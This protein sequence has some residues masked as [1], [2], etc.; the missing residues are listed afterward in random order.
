MSLENY[1]CRR[2]TAEPETYQVS[3]ARSGHTVVTFEDSQEAG[4]RAETQRFDVTFV[5][6]RL[7][8]RDDSSGPPNQELAAQP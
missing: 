8:Q 1:G 3:A 5:G 6:M 4:Q 2:R 7:P